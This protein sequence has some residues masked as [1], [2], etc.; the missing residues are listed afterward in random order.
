MKKLFFLLLVL[1][2]AA[3]GCT[4]RPVTA[5]ASPA[6]DIGRVEISLAYNHRSGI[7]SNQFAVWIE[8]GEGQFIKTLY[9]T[10]FTAKGGWEFRPDALP[11]WVERSGLSAGAAGN[12][13]A[14]SGATPKTGTHTYEWD[15]ADESGRP[16][17]E[18]EY[19][20]FVEGTIFW[21]DAVLYK[22]VVTV[23]GGENTAQFGAEYTTEEAKSSNM[24]T[25]VGA[26]YR[27]SH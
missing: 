23:G 24:I 16:V 3:T 12:T 22:G 25:D 4:G 11:V 20:I 10:R 21:R 27:P 2:A 26:V 1:A 9:A 17:P 15:C 5:A 7:A 18:G 13:D 8:D 19:H 14:F 6:G